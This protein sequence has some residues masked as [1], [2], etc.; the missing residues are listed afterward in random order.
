MKTC[1]KCRV[2]KPLSEFY[3]HPRMADGHLNKCRDCAKRDVTWHRGANI[4][5]IRAYDRAR[6]KLPHVAARI[7]RTTRAWRLANPEKA[8]AHNAVSN[9]IRCGK[10]KRKPCEVC[11]S[12]RS[13]GHHH[14]YSK[15]LDVRWLCA[16]HHQ[17][18]HH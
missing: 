13:H 16:A 18:E 14:D 8:R 2:E 5:A 12:E 11:G 3:R 15:P 1:F 9:A 4:E 7:S 6:A 10:L 17:A